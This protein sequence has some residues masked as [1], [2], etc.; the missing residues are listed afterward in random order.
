MASEIKL[1][2][3]GVSGSK[4]TTTDL[5]DGEIAVNTR[6]N[7]VFVANT[8]H[9]FEVGSV[10]TTNTTI[11]STPAVF[12]DTTNDRLGIG[13]NNPSYALD[14]TGDINLSNGIRVNGTSGTDGQI[15]AANTTGG[16]EWRDDVEVYNH[17]WAV[18]G[19]ITAVT[20]PC[21]FVLT[22]NTS[23]YNEVVEFGRYRA[24][25]NSGTSVDVKFQK[26]GVDI[27]SSSQTITTAKQTITAFTANT[28]VNEDELTVVTSSPSGSP[29]NLSVTA[30]FT[31]K[32]YID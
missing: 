22:G 31:R 9:V 7:I 28:M 12:V 25:I 1:K 14:V 26:N 24:K 10:L 8:T 5:S 2:R 23:G 6:D 11:G 27:P 21:M 19:D 4:P 13:K 32:R 16:I 3:S 29:V 20:L 30:F 15:L 18:A 17:T